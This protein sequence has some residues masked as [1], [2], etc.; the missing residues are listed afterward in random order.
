MALLERDVAVEA[1]QMV[2]QQQQWQQQQQSQQQQQ[3]Q[4]SQQQQDGSPRRAL[5]HTTH[6][7]QLQRSPYTQEQLLT[8]ID[9]L[10]QELAEYRAHTTQLETSHADLQEQLE[11]ELQKG[12]EW[13]A[14]VRSLHGDIDAACAAAREATAAKLLIDSESSHVKL[15]LM[16]LRRLIAA[17]NKM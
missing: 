4:Q 6:D 8:H 14:T 13:E 2:L 15:E 10:Q 9:Q 1:L 5:H 11:L 17:P 7:P 3:Q 12:V 16:R